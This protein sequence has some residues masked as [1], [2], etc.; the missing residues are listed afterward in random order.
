M[1]FI[2]QRL[3]KG[4]QCYLCRSTSNR[5]SQPDGNT[6]ETA[7]GGVNIFKVLMRDKRLVLGGGVT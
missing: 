3:R 2:S 6:G 1:V 4:R 7:G 5:Y